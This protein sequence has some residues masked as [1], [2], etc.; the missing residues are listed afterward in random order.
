[1]ITQEEKNERAM[2]VAN[3]A[4]KMLTDKTE[5]LNKMS[6]RLQGVERTTEG[7]LAEMKL[8]KCLALTGKIYVKTYAQDCDGVCNYSNSVFTSMDDY[9]EAYDSWCDSIEGRCSWEVVPKSELHDEE[10]CGT[11]GHGWDIV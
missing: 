3:F 11:F 1:M 10:D 7:Y 5:E 9:N 8:W 4:M 2:G 6:D